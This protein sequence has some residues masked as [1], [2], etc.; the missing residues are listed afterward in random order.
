M[1]LCILC[2]NSIDFKYK[3][4]VSLALALAQRRVQ[5]LV[6]HETTCKGTANKHVASI[7]GCGDKESGVVRVERANR[8]FAFLL[9]KVV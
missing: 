6:Q 5:C 9:Q 1:G 7:A 3:C 4:N 8:G 2:T